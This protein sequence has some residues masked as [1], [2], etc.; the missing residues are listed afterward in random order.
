MRRCAKQSSVL[1]KKQTLQTFK[2]KSRKINI[3]W[4]IN[5]RAFLVTN[6]ATPYT[7]AEQEI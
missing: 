1:N 4:S 2:A 3:K 7:N 5:T 6:S